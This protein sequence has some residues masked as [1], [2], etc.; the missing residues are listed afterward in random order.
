VLRESDGII[1]LLPDEEASDAEPFIEAYNRIRS[2]EQWGGDDLDLP[3]H[4]KRHRHIWEI[5]SRTF[6][7]FESA[8]SRVPRGL[9]LDIGA[10]NCWMTR[11]LDRWGF[12]AIALDINC[13]E[14]DGLRAGQKYI[15]E[16]A[17]FL[18]ARCSMERLPF[19][20]G[21]IRLVATSASFHYASNFRATL[22]EFE[23]VL[24]LGGMI[25]ITDTPV[26]QQP[27]AGDRM[28][29]E[30]VVEFGRKYGIPEA[31]SRKSQYMTYKQIQELGT[32]LGLRVSIR[33]VWPGVARKY[34]EVRGLLAGRQV[35]RFPLVLMEK[36]Q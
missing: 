31:L 21:R 3:F 36:S 2:D 1:N 24:T 11:Y 8:V 15:D 13:S 14:V 17:R 10:G 4:A 30:R 27:S 7:A 6:R 28:V 16:G 18:R 29:S 19:V 20:S 25:A 9:A 5:R 33:P 12:D 22:A 26:Y 23:R 35:A 32:S 34:E